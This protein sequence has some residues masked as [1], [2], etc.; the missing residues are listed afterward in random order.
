MDKQAVHC[1]AVKAPSRHKQ[2]YGSWTRREKV[3]YRGCCAASPVFVSLPSVLRYSSDP[4]PLTSS[5]PYIPKNASWFWTLR[6]YTQSAV[7]A[8]EHNKH[9]QGTVQRACLTDTAWP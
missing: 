4:V 9:V 1:T 5:E 2:A 6:G 7:S 8:Q 3:V